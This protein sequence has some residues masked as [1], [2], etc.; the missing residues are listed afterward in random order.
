MPQAMDSLN[1]ELH[2]LHH[3]LRKGTDTGTQLDK[4]C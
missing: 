1:H 4:S 2:E 3:E